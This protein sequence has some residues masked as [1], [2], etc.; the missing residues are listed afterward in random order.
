MIFQR[1]LGPK[2]AKAAGQRLYAAAVAQARTPALYA[3]LGAPDT[4]S[5]RF[6]VYTL[7][8]ILLLE[9]LRGEGPG[10]AEASQALFDTYLSGL[11]NGLR[12]LGVGDLSVGK[13]MRKMAEAFYGRA[14]GYDS[15][16]A[17]LPD[18]A[19]LEELL[20]RTVFDAGQPPAR[21]AAYVAA[22]RQGLAGQT[23]AALLDGKPAW[24]AP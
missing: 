14:Q 4:A 5:G 6:E 1:L 11:D 18:L 17:A 8:V 10:V 16:A 13:T 9:R 23:L 19:P 15:A 12:E 21:L 2:P 7:H 22:A 3:D 24:P 20:S